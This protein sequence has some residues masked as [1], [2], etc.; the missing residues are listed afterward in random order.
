MNTQLINIQPGTEKSARLTFSGLHLIL[1]QREIR[2]LESA[3]AVDS[4]D[5]G[6]LSAGWITCEQLRWPVYCIS[7]Q[8]TLLDTVPA[9]RR[10]CVLIKAGNNFMG[11]LCDNVSIE[12]AVEKWHDIPTAMILP[13][14]PLLGLIVSEENALACLTSAELLAAHI[15]RLAGV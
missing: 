14:T 3:S 7:P 9:E 4:R 5:A 13:V 12:K 1:P 11:I 10:V 8:L 15:I 2:M 6:A